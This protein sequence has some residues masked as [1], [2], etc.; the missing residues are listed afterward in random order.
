MK[1]LS[2]EEMSMDRCVNCKH[3]RQDEFNRIWCVANNNST[4]PE[5]VCPLYKC[6]EKED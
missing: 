5:C 2:I 1:E 4:Y 3:F 6:K